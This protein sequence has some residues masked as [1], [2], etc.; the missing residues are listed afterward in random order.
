MSEP[1]EIRRKPGRQAWQQA[2]FVAIVIVG[3]LGLALPTLT[4]AATRDLATQ[5]QASAVFLGGVALLAVVSGL[6]RVKHV[7]RLLTRDAV[8]LLTDQGVMMRTGSLADD[9][10]WAKLAWADVLEIEVRPAVLTPPLVR[11]R[12]EM[13]VLRFVAR[14]DDAIRVDSITGYDAVKG[15]ALGLTPLAACTAMLLRESSHDRVEL[16]RRWVGA[17]RPELAAFNSQP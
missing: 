14:D 10:R 9:K 16:I 11:E 17:N 4:S 3:G 5:Q 15:A 2:G 13:T 8:L 1:L 6:L 12:T 7:R